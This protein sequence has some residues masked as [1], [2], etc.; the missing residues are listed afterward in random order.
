M[1]GINL[2]PA[3]SGV[4]EHKDKSGY[5]RL[6][7]FLTAATVP[8]ALLAVGCSESSP[9][10]AM[11]AQGSKIEEKQNSKDIEKAD[12]KILRDCL[13]RVA[14]GEAS[15]DVSE[16]GN[17]LVRVDG[18]TYYRLDDESADKV[19]AVAKENIPWGSFKRAEEEIQTQKVRNAIIEFGQ[20]ANFDQLTPELQKSENVRKNW[21]DKEIK[22]TEAGSKTDQKWRPEP[23]NKINPEAKDF[24]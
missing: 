3:E 21:G 8:L 24:L 23:E 22:S 9:K 12:Q 4:K 2:T 14:G 18:S 20:I 6:K 7:R 5:K 10:S 17:Y 11:G 19:L 13:M 1:E 16:D 15:F